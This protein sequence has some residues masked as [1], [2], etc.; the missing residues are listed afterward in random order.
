MKKAAPLKPLGFQNPTLEELKLNW[1]T[2]KANPSVTAAVTTVRMEC[3]AKNVAITAK[4]NS[5][6]IGPREIRPAK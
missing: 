1:D 2:T 5:N 4:K 6:E 3:I